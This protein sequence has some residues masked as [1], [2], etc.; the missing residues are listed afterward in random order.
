MMHY[1]FGAPDA[2]VVAIEDRLDQNDY[3]MYAKLE[4][5]LLLAATKKDY[6]Q[7]L[8]EVVDFYGAKFNETELETHLELFSHNVMDINCAGNELTFRDVHAHFTSLSPA[9]LL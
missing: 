3:S 4:Q 9:Q 5:L 8:R 7:I 6:T 2:A 1:N